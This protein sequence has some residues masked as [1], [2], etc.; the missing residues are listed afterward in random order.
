MFRVGQRSQWKVLLK[1][2]PYD[3]LAHLASSKR[4]TLPFGYSQYGRIRSS[5]VVIFLNFLIV[6]V[7]GL[8][9][10]LDY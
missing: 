8:T 3:E 1:Q 6:S 5:T 2:G 9:H 7:D 10:N 4:Q